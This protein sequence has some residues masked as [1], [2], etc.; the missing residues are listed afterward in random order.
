[1]LIF[2]FSFFSSFVTASYSSRTACSG[3]CVAR[4]TIM[5]A[6][7]ASR[8]AGSS[9]INAPDTAHGTN[10]IFPYEYH[11]TAD[12]HACQC[13]LLIGASPEQ[14][15]Q[16]NGAECR[17]EACP[18]EGY[19]TENGAVG[20]SRNEGCNHGNYQN[21]N[22][23]RLHCPP[24]RKYSHG[25]SRP[26]DYGKCWRMPPEAE[27]PP[28]TSLPPEYRKAQYLQRLPQGSHACSAGR[29]CIR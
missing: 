6:A 2:Y 8:N 23:C 10:Q 17:A 1:M 19:D 3:A 25:R 16:H 18:C 26:K 20:V 29:K 7:R 13:A 5:I 22:S 15:C 21:G 14:R 11:H 28:W 4:L 12:N 27:N 24:F 9:F